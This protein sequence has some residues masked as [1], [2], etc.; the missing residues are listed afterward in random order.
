[1]RHWHFWTGAAAAETETKEEASEKKAQRAISDSQDLLIESE[2]REID[3]EK[4]SSLFFETAAS[5][6]RQRQ[7]RTK[8]VT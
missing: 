4:E 7:K 2:L 8:N 6:K 5:Q 3:R 1:M